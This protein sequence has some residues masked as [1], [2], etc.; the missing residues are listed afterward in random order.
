M[1]VSGTFSFWISILGLIG[2]ILSSI[3]GLT[4]AILSFV[5]GVTAGVGSLIG[6]LV[7]VVVS[8]VGGVIGG[9]VSFVGGFAG[10]MES[11][12]GITIT[13]IVSFFKI[14]SLVGCVVSFT[15]EV[16]FSTNT[17]VFGGGIELF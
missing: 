1:R 9:N 4:G 6:G 11:F 17:V 16:T 7:G 8:F 2:F 14:V 5:G 13:L 3:R 12:V 15:N 10:G